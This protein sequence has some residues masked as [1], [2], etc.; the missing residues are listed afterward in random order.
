MKN[1]LVR[2]HHVCHSFASY[3]RKDLKFKIQKM[4]KTFVNDLVVK[5]HLNG[6]QGRS[7]GGEGRPPTTQGAKIRNLKH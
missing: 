6:L 3:L 1:V 4:V 7:K 2:S 5:W